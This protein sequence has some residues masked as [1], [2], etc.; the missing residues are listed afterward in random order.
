MRGDLPPTKLVW[1]DGGK[2]PPAEL[3]LGQALSE[4]GSLLV[5]EKGIMLL[6]DAYGSTYRLLPEAASED[7]PKPPENLPRSPGHHQEWIQACK[8]GPAS[9]SSF[10]YA[11][12]LTETVLL[13]NLAIRLGR[14]VE[15]DAA[16]MKATGAPEADPWIRREY[17]DGWTL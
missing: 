5:G 14:R 17:R 10:D 16:G 3:A 9:L 6:P 2:K 11:S 4:N 13:G 12:R 1:Y 8:G 15:W 7:L